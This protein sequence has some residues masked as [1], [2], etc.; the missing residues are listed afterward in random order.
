MRMKTMIFFLLAGILL[1]SNCGK[2]N[3]P[4]SLGDTANIFKSPCSSSDTDSMYVQEEI[5]SEQWIERLVFFSNSSCQNKSDDLQYIMSITEAGETSAALDNTGIIKNVKKIDM[6]LVKILI[7]IFDPI[8]VAQNNQSAYCGYTDWLVGVPKDV[9]G[10]SCS[11]V[12]NPIAGTKLYGL[13]LIEGSKLYM[14]LK[15]IEHSGTS[16]ATRPVKITDKG[17]I[18]Q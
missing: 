16:D 18:K 8:Y 10:M 13:Y 15:D 1:L 6:T 11:G 17:L 12:N 3:S 2:N 4:E 5:S 7:T 14:H 9:T